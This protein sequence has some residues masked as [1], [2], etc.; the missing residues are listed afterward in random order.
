V[1]GRA[2]RGIGGRVGRG[3]G[4]LLGVD[5]DALV[6]HIGDV[7]VVSVGGVGHGLGPAVGEGNRVRSAHGTVGI[8]GLGGVEGSLGVVVGNTV[9][10]GVGL[11]G[12]LSGGG[13]VGGGVV[14]GGRGVGGSG[15]DN[16]G[17]VRGR[18]VGGGVVHGGDTDDGSVDG[19]HGSVDGVDGSVHGVVDGGN[20][21]DGGSVVGC[22]DGVSD[23][24]SVSVLDGGVRGHVG[25]GDGQTNQGGDNENLIVRLDVTC[26]KCDLRCELHFNIAMRHR[27]VIIVIAT[28][29]VS[30]RSHV[31]LLLLGLFLSSLSHSAT[32]SATS[33]SRTGCAAATTS[34]SRGDHEFVE[35][36]FAKG[37]DKEGRPVRLAN[38]AGLLEE[39]LNGILRDV[40]ALSV[41]DHCSV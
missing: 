29:H 13:L 38:H 32:L 41:E 1:V 33:S 28:E 35:V 10:V 16:R 7:A 9:G 21:D 23:G 40:H 37:L 22:V 18:G 5:W 34:G 30:D 14:D 20:T 24:G 17:G 26:M 6:A 25:A 8:G 4:L 11:R 2:G 12:V 39:C 15:V 27:L 36:F 19:V 3:I 31:L